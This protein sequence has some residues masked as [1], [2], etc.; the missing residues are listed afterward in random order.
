MFHVEPRNELDEICTIITSHH[1]MRI[2]PLSGLLRVEHPFFATLYCK[3]GLAD[4]GGACGH[5][6]R[7]LLIQ[8]VF[9]QTT[10]SFTPWL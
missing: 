8:R 6:L 5:L 10:D 7:D 1:V 2:M 4:K 3:Q 9:R